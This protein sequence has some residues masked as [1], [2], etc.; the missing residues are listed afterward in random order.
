M[1]LGDTCVCIMCVCLIMLPKKKRIRANFSCRCW[2]GMFHVCIKIIIVILC[3]KY[4]V[5]VIIII[6]ILWHNELSIR[7]Q[8]M[9]F[10]SSARS[11]Y[12]ACTKKSN[13][14]YKQT[15]RPKDDSCLAVFKYIVFYLENNDTEQITVCDLVVMMG[16]ALNQRCGSDSHTIRAYSVPYMK[17]MLLK[18]FG[19]NI[20]I[21]QSEA[22]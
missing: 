11:K 15:G 7:D 12:S 3:R 20:T 10:A 8:T 21:L 18:Q 19:E 16:D 6:I 17:Q 14:H 5:Y 9:T 13:W 1:C 2:E 4:H 22:K